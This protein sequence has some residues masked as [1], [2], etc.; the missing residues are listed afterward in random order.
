MDLGQYDKALWT[1]CMWLMIIQSMRFLIQFEE[2][3]AL[4]SFICVIPEKYFKNTDWLLFFNIFG[5][6]AKNFSFELEL[7]RVAESISF[8]SV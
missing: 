8:C 5:T 7:L 6:S 1:R 3:K 4:N 2:Y